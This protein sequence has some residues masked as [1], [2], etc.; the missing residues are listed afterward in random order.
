M[1]NSDSPIQGNFPAAPHAAAPA[2]SARLTSGSAHAALGTVLGGEALRGPHFA[3]HDGSPETRGQ[4]PRGENSDRPAARSPAPSQRPVMLRCEGLTKNYRTGTV[5][6][7]VLRGVDLEV[8]EGE[9]TAIVGQSGSGKSTLLHLLA[10][11]DHPDSG[12]VHFDGN[13]IDNLP[14]TRRDLLRNKCFGMVFQFYHLL[15][16]LNAIENVLLPSMIA[17]GTWRYW[18]KRV[19]LRRRAVELLELVGLGHRL[20]HLPRQLSGGEMQR[21]AIARALMAAPKIVLADE[22]TGNLDRHTGADVMNILRSL[23]VQQN[24]TIVMVTHDQSIAAQADRT[25]RLVEGRMEESL[26]L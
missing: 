13:R 17:Y 12:Q 14:A 8:R 20:R 23:N 22:P 7:P 6:V 18:T 9:F 1:N 5:Q 26:D 15:P 19:P 16:E 21:V 3:L 11:L 24:L 2:T 10:T 25:V 4:L